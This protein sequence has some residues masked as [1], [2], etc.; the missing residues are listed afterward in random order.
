M[1]R[2]RAAE[3]PFATKQSQASPNPGREPGGVRAHAHLC[4][5]ERWST[6]C[7]DLGIGCCLLRARPGSVDPA[8]KTNPCPSPLS[9]VRAR[10]PARALARPGGS[11]TLIQGRSLNVAKG[12]DGRVKKRAPILR[13]CSLGDWVPPVGESLSLVSFFFPLSRENVQESCYS[14]GP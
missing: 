14:P 12:I 7:A 2:R 13:S 5:P 6:R 1:L 8:T 10:L 3:S 9:S 4:T 11:S